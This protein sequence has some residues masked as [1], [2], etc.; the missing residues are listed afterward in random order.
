LRLSLRPWR[1]APLSQVFS[2]VA[3]GFLLLLAGFLFWMER[4]LKPVV[5]RL[6]REQ[7][8]TA[9]LDP[10]VDAK[11]EGALVDS[12]R[13]AVGAHAEV[14]LVGAP[15]FVA[16]LRAQYPELARELEDLGGELGAVVPRFVSATGVLPGPA[17]DRVRAIK[18]VEAAESSRERHQHVVG[19]FVALR[20]VA[21]LL[22]AGLC[23]ALFTGLLHL[24]RMNSYLH[25]DALAL[26][27]LW[28][29]GGVALRAPALVSGLG[30]GILGGLV[31]LLAWV[32]GGVWLAGQLRALSPMLRDLSL[33]SANLGL[34]LLFVGAAL[35]VLAGA[36]SRIPGGASSAS[37]RA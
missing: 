19:A 16:D 37:A 31:A 17:L 6:E 15:Q 26:L 28:G 22:V 24:A 21:R 27:R 25:Q 7:V 1:L 3:V 29:A 9:Y 12:I 8:I 10:A 30:V 20:W 36:L 14:K 18:G 23:L 2:A 11:D 33:P 34:A 35:G 13:T 5:H 4:G 32:T